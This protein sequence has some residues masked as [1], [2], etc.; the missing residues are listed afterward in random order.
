MS[1]RIGVEIGPRRIRAVGLGRGV[2]REAVELDWDGVAIA[3]AM[4]E[5]RERLG[6]ARV[7]AIALDPEW[8]FA[9]R[10]RLPP[11]TAE[12][13][14]RILTLEPE[15]F[16]PVRGEALVVATRA[17]D[18]LVFAARQSQLE[19]WVA[20]A[21]R[22]GPVERVEPGPEALARTLA[23]AGVVDGTVIHAGVPGQV[24]AIRIAGG[25]VAASR[26]VRGS[27]ADA[28][29]AGVDG[30]V[31]TT[32]LY[33]APWSDA[34]AAEV[35]ERVPGATVGPVPAPEGLAPDFACAYGAVLGLREGD[36]SG[37]VPP[38]LARR[39]VRRRRGRAGLAVAAL[40]VACAFGLFSLDASRTR[41]ATRV[42]AE[43]A[44]LRS[45][46]ADIVALQAEGARLEA[47]VRVLDAIAGDRP[48]VLDVLL[49][50]SRLLPADAYLRGIGGGAG[51]QWELDGYARNAAGLI[52]VLESSAAF[53]D[54]RF[55]A[56]TMRMRVGNDEYESF[57]LALRHVPTP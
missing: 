20:A 17:D 46:T 5:L 34:A 43:L 30:E 25:R 57:A 11:V 2:R 19:G 39:L 53:A 42:D 48:N 28:A 35:R 55:R 21:E 32:D 54:V 7:V 4:A 45:E 29:A 56:A 15:R 3:A 23:A 26:R 40:V 22:L 1:Y 18:D 14:A 41:A 24:A 47:E 27:A 37:L 13:R 8:M 50:V 16:F 12:E 6:P 49:E 9:K 52:P 10:V 51:D 44:R 33:L 38:G 31:G 36:G